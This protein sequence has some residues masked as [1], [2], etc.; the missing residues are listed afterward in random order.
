MYNP[1]GYVWV[2]IFAGPVAFIVMAC[3]VLYGGALRAGLP[4]W[5]ATLVA[6]GTAIVPGGWL[7]ISAMLAG[8]GWYNSTSGFPLLPVATLG[9]LGVF[10]ALSQVP[11]MRQALAAPGMLSRLILPQTVRV[12]GAAPLMYLA[13][14][15][16]PALFA[17][18][19][20]LG[21]ITAGIAA[22]FVARRLARGARPREG[23]WFNVFGITDLVVSSILGALTGYHLIKVTPAA[24]LSQLPIA[25]V[26]T[27]VVPMLLALHVI[28]LRALAGAANTA[29]PLSPQPIAA[30]A[31]AATCA[32]GVRR[33]RYGAQ[34][35]GTGLTEVHRGQ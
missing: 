2:T 35:A 3:V 14:G 34:T 23:V 10:I 7:G 13:L 4:R 12:T 30:A 22:P 1:P 17:V 5:K 31:V 8:H 21:D 25:L 32:G 33:D 27:A 9:A 16:L 26:P 24:D 18:P 29:Q 28:S 11:V 15:H 6:A 20:A 19:A